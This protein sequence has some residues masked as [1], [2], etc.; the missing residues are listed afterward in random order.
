MGSGAERGRIIFG[1]EFARLL[2]SASRPETL[3]E[4]VLAPTVVDGGLES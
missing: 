3:S 4:K 2:V 1:A